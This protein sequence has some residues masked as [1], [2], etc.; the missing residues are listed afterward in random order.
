[1]DTAQWAPTWIGLVLS[2]WLVTSWL[3][4]AW[5]GQLDRSLAWGAA[6]GFF[7]L[8]ATVVTYLLLAGE[9]RAGLFPGL[10]L[11]AVGAGPGYGTAGAAVH[12]RARGRLIAAVVLGATFVV[13]GV[14]LLQAAAESPVE[15]GLLVAEAAAGVLL[16]SWIGGVRAGLVVVIVGAVVLGI[17]LAIMV[18]MGPGLP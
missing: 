18:N 1:M 5:V 7:L 10:P 8:A 16:A 17:E 6:A 15:S 9:D 14:L 12:H 13:E 11:L 3:A 4:G 2:P